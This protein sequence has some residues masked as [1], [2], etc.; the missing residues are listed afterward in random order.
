ML[1]IAP[2][3][4]WRT[5]HFA[6]HA[7]PDLPEALITGRERVYLDWFLRRKAANPL[8]FSDA[9]IDEYVRIF[10]LPGALRA[11]LAFYRAASISAEQNRTLVRDG[12]LSMP[13]LA[14]SADQG[15]IPD[16]VAPLRP[17]A[18]DLRGNTVSSSGHFIPEEQPEAVA[19]LFGE[20][21]AS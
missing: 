3:R 9:D 20:F 18:D 8:N 11:G 13:V 19:Q 6:F 12:K 14:V 5:W 2:D 10:S 16:M 4:A 1:P 17:F 7:I 21:F 15:S